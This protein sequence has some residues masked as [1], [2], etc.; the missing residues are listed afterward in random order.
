MLLVLGFLLPS[1]I[2]LVRA[3]P[4][5]TSPAIQ[6]RQP[7]AATPKPDVASSVATI[8]YEYIS[9]S[10]TVN[11]T[12][13]LTDNFADLGPTGSYSEYAP[14]SSD[15]CGPKVQDGYTPP[16]CD[17]S[18][19][20]TADLDSM[21]GLSYDYSYVYPTEDPAPYG[22][23]CI[24]ST[25]TQAAINSNS[26]RVTVADICNKMTSKYSP[27]AKWVWSTLGGSGCAIGYY[28]PPYNGSAPVPQKNRCKEGIYGGML[29]I[30]VTQPTF[31]DFGVSNLMAVNIK[32]LPSG[33]KNGAAVNVGYPSYIIAPAPLT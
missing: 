33:S 23:Q 13:T 27:K 4:P 2:G 25:S 18:L 28:L 19:N 9:G 11:Q 32:A 10:K 1:I 16:T 21:D 30:C 12:Q 31:F 20:S 22:V 17:T 7:A 24:N 15:P 3:F 26:C 8:V 5:V 29:D 14:A 6:P